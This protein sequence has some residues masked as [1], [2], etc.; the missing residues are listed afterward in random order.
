MGITISI[1]QYI[2]L[3]PSITDESRC[4]LYIYEVCVLNVIIPGLLLI[5]IGGGWVVGDLFFSPFVPYPDL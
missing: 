5:Q 4:C 3:V 1:K 2:A